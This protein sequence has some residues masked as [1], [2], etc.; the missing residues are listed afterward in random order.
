MI[1]IIKELKEALNEAMNEYTIG[2][3]ST[4]DLIDTN[5]MHT[6]FAQIPYMVQIYLCTKIIIH[7]L[8]IIQ[9]WTLCQIAFFN[10]LLLV[11]I[12]SDYTVYL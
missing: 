12:D 6:F 4:L 7:K 9:F 11:L 10:Y 1:E 2:I 8:W 5:D 3:Q